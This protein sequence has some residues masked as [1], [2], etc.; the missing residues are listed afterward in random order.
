MP[1]QILNVGTGMYVGAG[2]P[3]NSHIARQ[4]ELQA[5]EF[6]GVDTNYPDNSLVD[7]AALSPYWPGGGRF[8]GEG[9]TLL[10]A[11]PDHSP[12]KIAT[13]GN[14]Q[15][16]FSG[17]TRDGNNSPVGGMTVRLFRTSDSTLV[18][19]TVSRYDGSYNVSTPY[20]GQ[21]HFITCHKA[22]SP[23]IAGASQSTLQP[24]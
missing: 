5:E 17:V 9:A 22:G 1:S 21:D 12:R 16:G 18:A 24:W 6:Y 13:G 11:S 4:R 19:T 15:L 2:L 20:A 14:S 23:E 10:I 8:T 7:Q 3:F